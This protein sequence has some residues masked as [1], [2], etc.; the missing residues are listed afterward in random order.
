VFAGHETTKNQLGWMMV[1]LAEVPEEWE[2][3]ARDPGRAKDVI[4]EV[5]RFRSAATSL[6]RMALED[7][8]LFGESIPRGGSVIASLWSANRDPEEFARPDA[9]DVDANREGVQMA[10]GSGAHHCLGAALA[11]A[12]LQESLIALSRK[13]K[14]PRIAEGATFLPPLGINGPSS[15][16]ITFA[17]R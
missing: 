4:E 14:S 6:G 11:R 12:E 1:V 3:V 15:L 13:M 9:F 2:R 5:L 10:F 17:A 8:E 7:V 16:P